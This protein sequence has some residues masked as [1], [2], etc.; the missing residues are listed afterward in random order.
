VG[1]REQR[2]VEDGDKKTRRKENALINYAKRGDN[3]RWIS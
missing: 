2:E 3:K 1:R